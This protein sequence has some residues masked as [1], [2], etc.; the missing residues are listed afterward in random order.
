VELLGWKPRS[1]G[2][3]GNERS[4]GAVE[5]LGWKPRPRGAVGAER[6]VIENWITNSLIDRA[7]NGEYDEQSK[8]REHADNRNFCHSLMPPGEENKEEQREGKE[9]W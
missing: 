7:C 8:Q 2:A 6:A 3:V 5:L 4:G 9:D 1:R